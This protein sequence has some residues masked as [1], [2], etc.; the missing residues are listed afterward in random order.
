MPPARL[1]QTGCVGRSPRLRLE[2]AI[3]GS[4]SMARKIVVWTVACSDSLGEAWTS[5]DRC[6]REDGDTPLGE[7]LV[8][9]QDGIILGGGAFTN[10]VSRR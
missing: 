3:C 7:S 5:C 6:S 9:D 1:L 4:W 8:S 2:Q 10:V